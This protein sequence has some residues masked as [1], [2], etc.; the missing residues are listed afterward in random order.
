MIA[1][2]NTPQD[3]IA[4]ISGILGWKRYV[5]RVVSGDA[6]SPRP[7]LAEGGKG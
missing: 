5:G 3:A 4:S 7:Q 6:P 1:V 2:Y